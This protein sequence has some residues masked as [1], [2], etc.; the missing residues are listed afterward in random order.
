[1]DESTQIHA[2][3]FEVGPLLADWQHHVSTCITAAI[4]GPRLWTTTKQLLNLA[5]KLEACES[6]PFQFSNVNLD[7]SP[8]VVFSCNP[9]I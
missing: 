6:G 5:L 4:N 3:Q 7:S 8:L 2:L 9:E 1:M